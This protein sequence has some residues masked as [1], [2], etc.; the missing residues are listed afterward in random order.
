M[1]GAGSAG[2]IRVHDL[3]EYPTRHGPKGTP[4]LGPL[5][6]PLRPW[7]LLQPIQ[8][9]E[10][11]LDTQVAAGHHVQTPETEDEEHLGAP[12]TDPPHLLF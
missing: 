5:Q 1:S 9:A 10:P 2:E 8:D 6:D 12:L 11:L 3:P 7:P 4:G